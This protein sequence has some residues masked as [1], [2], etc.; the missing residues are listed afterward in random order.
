MDNKEIEL[1]RGYLTTGQG[2]VPSVLGKLLDGLSD[3]ELA[4]LR[5]AALEGKLSIELEQQRMAIRYL[6]A[7]AEMNEFIS[8]IKQYES[9][10]NPAKSLS[11]IRDTREISGASGTTTVSYRRGCFVASCVYGS[12]SHPDVIILRGFRHAVL[13]QFSQGRRLSAWYYSNGLRLAKRVNG[14]M[15]KSVIRCVLWSLCRLITLAE[16]PLTCLLRPLNAK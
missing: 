14:P 5:V 13:E 1:F 2:Q 9:L 3:A 11:G 10:P 12:S 15:Q 6:G 16:R 7:R 4:K 8:A